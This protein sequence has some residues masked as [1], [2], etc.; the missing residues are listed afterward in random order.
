MRKR[1]G[2]PVAPLQ[3]HGDHPGGESARCARACTTDRRSIHDTSARAG[4][5]NGR[6]TLFSS[7][8]AALLSEPPPVACS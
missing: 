1:P 6:G 2:A 4:F 3:A 7:P 5:E 8:L